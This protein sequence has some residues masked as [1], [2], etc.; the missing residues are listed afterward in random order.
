MAYEK[1]NQWN[2]EEES[3]KKALVIIN[4]H[5]FVLNYLGYVWLE[6][7][8]N[9]NE[10]L[11]MIFE[12]FQQNPESGHIMDSMGRA[13]YRMQ[14]YE[15]AVSILER[16]A[17][18]LPANAVVCDHLGDV[19]WHLGRKKE[20]KYQWT[21]ALSLKEDAELLDKEQVHKK[22]QDGAPEPI[23]IIYNEALLIERL[24]LLK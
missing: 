15:D 9:Y 20:A 14:K 8:Q 2:K 18:Y 17:E 13:L 4:R 1:N 6:N 10:A 23:S 21:Q 11:Y 22:L 3:L 12:A 19:Y 5:P 7:N 24:K 16:A